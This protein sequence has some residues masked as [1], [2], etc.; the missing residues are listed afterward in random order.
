MGSE[1][2]GLQEH[3][4]ENCLYCVGAS[5]L[6]YPTQPQF[7]SGHARTGELAGT[8]AVL[9]KSPVNTSADCDEAMFLFLVIVACVF[10]KSVE[11]WEILTLK[12]THTHICMY[13]HI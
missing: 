9:L 10:L 6:G 1:E 12:H 13:K 11:N 2:T 4:E 5:V 7:H 3:T 8:Q